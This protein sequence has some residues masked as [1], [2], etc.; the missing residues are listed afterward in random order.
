M[1][2]IMSAVL[3]LCLVL[4]LLFVRLPLE[5]M[6]A[7]SRAIRRS[8]VRSAYSDPGRLDGYFATYSSDH[9]IS[10]SGSDDILEQS[11]SSED[12]SMIGRGNDHN[13]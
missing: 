1:G 6:T 2:I 8:H 13:F 4:L 5:S 9:P 10:I 12:I 7:S 3:L 11:G